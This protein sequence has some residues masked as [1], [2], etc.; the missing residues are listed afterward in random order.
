[1]AKSGSNPDPGVGSGRELRIQKYLARAGVASRR[2]AEQLLAQGRVRLNGA[3]VTRPG[4]RV[5]PGRDRVEVDGR[6]VEPEPFRWVMVHKPSGTV[7]T[8]DDPEGRPTIYDLLPEQHRSLAYVGRLDVETEGLLLLSNEGD[9]VHRLLH[10]SFEVEREYAVGVKGVPTG[11][12]LRRMR[13]GIEL[14]DGPV[15]P[16]RAEQRGSEP[17]GAVLRLVLTEGRKREVRR[18]CSAAGHPVRW[19]RRVR[20][21]PVAL[22]DLPR[23][24][25]RELT[26]SEV[27][28]VRRRAARGPAKKGSGRARPG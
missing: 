8:A 10:P 12:T 20:F 4:A 17:G 27:E 22:G 1:M 25:W 23:G 13:R 16:R 21:G 26:E 9:A 5:L 3:V 7:T 15:R 14:D 2:G 19:L 28:A 18:L 24:Q 11:Q 6:A